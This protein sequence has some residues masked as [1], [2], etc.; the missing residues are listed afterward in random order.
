MQFMLTRYEILRS[1]ILVSCKNALP[2]IPPSLLPYLHPWQ[3]GLAF[4]S[5]LFWDYYASKSHKKMKEKESRFEERK[6]HLKLRNVFHE[7]LLTKQTKANTTVPVGF[8]DSLLSHDIV[9]FVCPSFCCILT[10][11]SCPK[12][13]TFGTTISLDRW[14]LI[15]R[16]FLKSMLTQSVHIWKVLFLFHFICKHFSLIQEEEGRLDCKYLLC[17]RL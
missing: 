9:A 10:N 15:G 7:Q 6:T 14:D 11:M 8:T 5:S 17:V 12:L 3:Q 1:P 16:G 13:L 2:D 4:C